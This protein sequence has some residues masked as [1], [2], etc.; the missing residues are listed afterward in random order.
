MNIAVFCLYA[1]IALAMMLFI[2]LR[3]F[4]ILQL[5]DYSYP[6][7]PV[8]AKKSSALIKCIPHIIVTLLSFAVL[9]VPSIVNTHS[10]MG[11]QKHGDPVYNPGGM[12]DVTLVLLAVA[13][14]IFIAYIIAVSLK[15]K[16][17]RHLVFDKKII[18]RTVL[19]LILISPFFIAA[20]MSSPLVHTIRLDG[21]EEEILR[22]RRNYPF[23][24]VN[25][26]VGLSPHLSAF[27]DAV[28]H[29]F[30]HKLSNRK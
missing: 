25:I 30:D 6:E 7:A 23:F 22:F 11:L 18:S 3:R 1:A 4:H 24:I 14:L 17:D 12:G 26:A 9:F 13:A 29:P 8:S 28:I 2:G 15:T 27:A 5:N 10:P 20:A 16:C 21:T 19:L